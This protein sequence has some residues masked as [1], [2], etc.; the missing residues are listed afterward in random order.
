MK[1]AILWVIVILVAVGGA[2]IY[3][4][5]KSSEIVDPVALAGEENG[6]ETL[7]ASL[8]S[9]IG[10]ES[11]I[12]EINQTLVDVAETTGAI[13]AADSLNVVS[14][15]QEA[16]SI[17]LS[18]NFTGFAGDNASLLELNQIFGEITQ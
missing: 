2:Y 12:N 16:N 9:S 8:V 15:G 5:N 3:F 4:K 6:I 10:D 14:I 1:T 13:N 11:V 18:Q 7:N 17:D